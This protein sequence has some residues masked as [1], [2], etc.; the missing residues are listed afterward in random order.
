LELPKANA[1][2]I[3]AELDSIGHR[4]HDSQAEAAVIVLIAARNYVR[5]ESWTVVFNVDDYGARCGDASNADGY[6]PVITEAV[7]D[8]ICQCLADCE[9]EFA[10]FPLG[11]TQARERGFN[12]RPRDRYV[13]A[14]VWK[15]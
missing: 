12:R 5:I 3:V 7:F 15:A 10:A 4:G 9:N 11:Q 2:A 13:R 8:S 6:I 1:P 14:P